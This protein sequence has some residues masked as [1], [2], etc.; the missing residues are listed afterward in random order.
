MAKISVSGSGSWGTALT[1]LLCNNG[2]ELTLW[3]YRAE[4]T[5]MYQKDH[6]NT[7]K[8][9]GVILPDSVEYTTD[10]G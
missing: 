3:S 6:Q 10:L 1:W 8:L 9:P 7:D 5:E 2:H 4:E